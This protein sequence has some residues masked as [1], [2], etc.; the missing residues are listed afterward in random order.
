MMRLRRG[1]WAPQI[2]VL[3]WFVLFLFLLADG[4][5]AQTAG[6][7]RTFGNSQ[8]DV[9]DAVR[10]LQK[11]SEGRLPILEGFVGTRPPTPLSSAPLG[12]DKANALPF[13][14]YEMGYYQCSIEVAPATGGGTRVRVNAKITAWYADPAQPGYRVLPS[15][16]LLETDFLDRLAQTL[17]RTRPTASTPGVI[18]PDAPRPPLKLDIPGPA[19]RSSI[20]F[21][22]SSDP[23]TAGAHASPATGSEVAPTEAG[24]AALR[25]EREAAEKRMKDLNQEAR[26]LEEILRNQARP[27]NL[28]A[29][30]KRAP[31]MSRASEAGGVLFHAV[32]EDEFEVLDLQGEWV[33]VQISGDLRGWIRRVSLELPEELERA[34]A[35]KNLYGLSAKEP[36]RPSREETGTFPGNWE[37]LRGKSVKIIWI[38]PVDRNQAKTPG[39]VK[40]DFAKTVLWNVSADPSRF[41][42]GVMGVVLVFDSADGG[43]VFA[44]LSSLQQWRA[45]ALTES[46][47][48]QQC[49]FDP[50]EAFE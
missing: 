48:W 5:F 45:G 18:K 9:E 33:H 11:F 47:F 23:P 7:E 8:S 22:G 15:N 26:N 39:N 38:Q 21:T 31:V 49:S 10:A 17:A 16:G 24:I 40:R 30:K 12:E 20:P 32:P 13:D 19:P 4:A 1:V 34:G 37:P 3:E 42:P 35:Q 29:V 2:R 43:M 36:F 6:S 27:K 41:E 14:R 25:A 46:T 44:T 50:T 28:A